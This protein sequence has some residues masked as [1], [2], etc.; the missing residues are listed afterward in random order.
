MKQEFINKMK[1][2]LLEERA[3]ILASLERQRDE[4]KSLISS[5]EAGDEADIASDAEGRHLLDS[6][7]EQAAQ[8]LQLINNALT[9]IQEGKYG[10]CLSCG[11]D[12]PQA[13]LERIPYAFMCVDCMEKAERNQR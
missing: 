6:L 13:R 9:R 1:K 2:N 4:F 7:G 11:K 3:S 10:V 8:R 12:I 5:V